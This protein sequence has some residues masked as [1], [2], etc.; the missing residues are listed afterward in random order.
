MIKAKFETV[1]TEIPQP[2]LKNFDNEADFKEMCASFKYDLI[3]VKYPNQKREKVQK[4]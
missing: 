2:V 3:W 1:C 4:K